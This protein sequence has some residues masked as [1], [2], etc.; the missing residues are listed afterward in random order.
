MMRKTWN[1]H[2]LACSM[3]FLAKFQKLERTVG[4]AMQQ[5]NHMLGLRS[6]F[7]QLGST[8]GVDPIPIERPEPVE[9]IE[10]LIVPRCRLRRPT[11]RGKPKSE[12]VAYADRCHNG[13]EEE[14]NPFDHVN[15]LIRL[16]DATGCCP[17]NRR[18]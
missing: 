17:R 6:M 4:K 3:K 5:H 14:K 9:A 11:V 12:Q 16:N 13:G 8:D 18:R 1:Q 15:P 2:R 10:R 7:E